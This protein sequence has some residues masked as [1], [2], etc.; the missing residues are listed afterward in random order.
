MFC[1]TILVCW[2]PRHLCSA[3]QKINSKCHMLWRS[4]PSPTI[5]LSHPHHSAPASIGC[6]TAFHGTRK[7]RFWVTTSNLQGSIFS[8]RTSKIF[9]ELSMYSMFHR[10]QQRPM[11]G[12]SSSLGSISL[13]PISPSTTCLLLT[14]WMSI[15]SCTLNTSTNEC[16]SCTYQPLGS[17]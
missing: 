5:F 8:K 17:L 10:F 13:H 3:L 4:R 2:Y 16:R 6:S 1:T 12:L 9:F 14:T 11:R 7:T 15:C